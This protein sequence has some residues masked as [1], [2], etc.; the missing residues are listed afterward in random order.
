MP[1]INPFDHVVSEFRIPPNEM[2]SLSTPTLAPSYTSI[3]AFQKALSHNAM[4]IYSSQTQLGHLHLVITEEKYLKANNNTKFQEPTD[5]DTTESTD[6]TPGVSTR[7]M[8]DISTTSDPT[9]TTLQSIKAYEYKKQTY[10]K[11]VATTIALRNLI[12][13]AVDDKYIN[14]LEDEDTGY[15]KVWRG[16]CREWRGH[17]EALEPISTYRNL[18]WAT[19]V[20]AG[21]CR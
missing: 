10:L 4:P 20:G 1:I 3:R 5:P 16:S 21:I 11:Y 6:S 8:L 18:V 17:E 14:E 19:Q 12:L 7:S 2:P 9:S 13:N 15:A